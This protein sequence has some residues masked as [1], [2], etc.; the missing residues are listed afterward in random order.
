MTHETDSA[1]SFDT[2][3][4][5]IWVTNGGFRKVGIYRAEVPANQ[6]FRRCVECEPIWA[7]LIRFNPESLE[8]K[9]L[10]YHHEL[11]QQEGKPENKVK[12]R[13]TT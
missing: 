3:Y 10:R 8:V 9:T 11:M 1:R 6:A 4:V 2:R 5:M 7:V 12:D 13:G